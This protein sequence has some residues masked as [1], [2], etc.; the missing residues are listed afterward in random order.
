MNFEFLEA[1]TE[2]DKDRLANIMAFGKDLE[3]MP[4][5]T[6]QESSSPEPEPEIDRF[7]EC[8]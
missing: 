3:Q 8:K 5:N 4:F 1:L 6:K 2:K 7:D